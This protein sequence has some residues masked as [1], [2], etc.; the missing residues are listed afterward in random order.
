MARRR[1]VVT[2][3]G[4]VSPVG[5]GVTQAWSNILAGKSGITPISRFDASSLSSR[6]AGEVK[7]FEVSQYLAPKEARRFDT[8]IHY[9]LAAGIDC[10]KD[11]GLDF[12][13]LN[14]E[15]IGACI[16]SGIGGLPL[17]E[18]THNAAI[19]GG[20]RKISP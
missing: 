9:G 6:I 14:L 2:G 19:E 15:R 12:D 4:I 18:S 13:C 17:I 10:I 20:A 8:F 16:G 5:I 1:V 11:A 3:L 7:G